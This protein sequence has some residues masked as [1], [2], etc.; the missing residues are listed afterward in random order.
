M[1]FSSRIKRT[2]LSLAVALGSITAGMAT[3][4]AAPA[5]AP[6][7]L[8]QPAV[9]STKFAGALP[10]QT[11]S[12]GEAKAT[13]TNGIALG[14]SSKDGKAVANARN[15]S[16]PAAIAIGKGAHAEARGVKPGL[17]IAIA[18]PNST[19]KVSGTD[20]AQCSGQ[21]GLAGDFQTLT[22]CVVYPT[23]KGPV[24]IPLDSRPLVKPLW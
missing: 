2:T 21:W 3:A 14:V 1:N 18:G 13:A 5:P 11:A 8:P 15:F 22:G 12:N 23:N 10:N 9:G 24:T 6:S 16:G 4:S 19:V 17:S 20:V 7:P